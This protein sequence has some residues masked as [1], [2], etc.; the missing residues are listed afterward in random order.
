MRNLV[1]SF[2]FWLPLGTLLL[3]AGVVILPA[4]L[5]FFRLKH[6]AN[7]ADTISLQAGEFQF[8]L[9]SNEFLSESFIRAT[10]SAKKL[11]TILDAPGIFGELLVSILAEYTGNWYPGPLTL[12]AWQSVTYPFFAIPAWVYVGRGLDALLRGLPVGTVSMVVSSVLTAL[13]ITISCGLRF[14]FSPSERND[15]V[16]WLIAGFALWS[17]LLFAISLIGWIRQRKAAHA[18]SV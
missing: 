15:N 3:A 5:F 8:R 12:T 1:K 6:G 18:A 11:I 17:L 14:G 10:Y 2:S 9:R 7:G 13:A 16:S 4:L